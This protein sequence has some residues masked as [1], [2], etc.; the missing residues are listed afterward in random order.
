MAYTSLVTRRIVLLLV[1][2]LVLV[3]AFAVSTLATRL[4]RVQERV[5]TQEEVYAGLRERP[6]EWAGRVVFLRATVVGSVSYRLCPVDQRTILP[7]HPPHCPDIGWIY[8]GSTT[9]QPKGV[10][11]NGFVVNAGWTPR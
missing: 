3:L 8:L 6:R 9:W 5:Y 4:V 7:G 11:L 1:G 2:L 10:G